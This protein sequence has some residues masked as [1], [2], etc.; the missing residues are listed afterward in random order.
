MRNLSF[1]RNFT[2]KRIADSAQ[3]VHSIYSTPKKRL[4]L[5]YS[6]YYLVIHADKNAFVLLVI[7]NRCIRFTGNPE[8][9]HSIYRSHNHLR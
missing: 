7:Q 6:A 9:V 1:Q 4:H 5:I 8:Q 3:K 2:S